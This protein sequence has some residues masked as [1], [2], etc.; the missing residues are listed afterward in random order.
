VGRLGA[1]LLTL[2]LGGCAL[3]CEK[4]AARTPLPSF[5]GSNVVIVLID[6]LRQD[7]LGAYG[8]EARPTSPQL[9][10]LA[11]EAVVFDHA[12]SAAPW[13]LPSI[14]SAFTSTWPTEH[15]VLATGQRLPDELVP[16]AERMHRLGYRTAAFVANPHAGTGSHMHR[17]YER[18]VTSVFE[19]DRPAVARWLD[20]VGTSPFLLYL[21]SVEPHHPYAAPRRYYTRL[22]VQPP[23]DHDALIEDARRYIDL[24][25]VGGGRDRIRAQRA[26]GEQASVLAGLAPRRQDLD[27]IYDAC[28]AW[29]DDNLGAVLALLRERGLLERTVVVVMSDHGEEIFDHGRLLHG[30]SVHAELTRVPFLFRL[31]G[32]AGAGTRVAAP[33]TLVDLVPTLLDLLGMEAELRDPALRGRSLRGLIA[34]DAPDGDEP[35]VASVRIEREFGFAGPPETGKVNIAVVEGPWKGIW[36]LEVG[37]FELYRTDDDPGEARDRAADEPEVV[38]RLQAAARAWYLDRPEELAEEPR[39]P[40]ETFSPEELER[41]RQLGYVE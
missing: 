17:G 24:I 23:L 27:V 16:L 3:G 13:T 12:Q 38:E 6:T 39:D 14:V 36:N 15:G 29:A 11:R 22:G 21:H 2:A 19:V 32:A 28:V 8:Y 25:Q 37:R 26:L 40:R 9:D 10:A 7:R 18:V 30:Q 35:R 34:G 41:L 4:E 33:V 1:L 5:A 31:P 20:E